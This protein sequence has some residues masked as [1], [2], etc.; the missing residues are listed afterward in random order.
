MLRR[1][2]KSTPFPYTT[3]FRSFDQCQQF[4]QRCDLVMRLGVVGLWHGAVAVEP[5]GAQSGVVCAGDVVREAVTE[6]RKSTRL[7]SSHRCS[8]YAVVCLKKEKYALARDY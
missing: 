5:D 4:P 6:D 7:N 8:S 3:L 2:P 1:P